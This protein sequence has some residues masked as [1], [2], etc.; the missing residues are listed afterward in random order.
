MTEHELSIDY[1][2]DDDIDE[3]WG[4]TGRGETYYGS[5]GSTAQQDS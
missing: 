1:D 4:T 2:F 3:E 5:S